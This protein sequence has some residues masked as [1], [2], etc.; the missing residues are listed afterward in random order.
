[1]S[2]GQELA[3]TNARLGVARVAQE[4]LQQPTSWVT[5]WLPHEIGELRKR[6]VGRVRR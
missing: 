3:E 6:V 1:M 4:R 2:L 5:E